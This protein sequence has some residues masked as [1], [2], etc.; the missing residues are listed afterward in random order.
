[1][2]RLRSIYLTS[3]YPQLQNLIKRD[4][5]SYREEYLQQLSH[6]ESSLEIFKLKPDEEAKDF[7]DLIS[8]LCHVSPLFPEQSKDFPQML[9][10][11][12][13]EHYEILNPFVRKAM[14]QGLIL[15]RK[16][17][18]VDQSQ[19]KIFPNNRL[20]SLF[21]KLFRCHDKVLRVV[22][23]HHIVG[24][25][26]NLNKMHKNNRVNSNLQNYMYSMLE[27]PVPIAARKSLLVMID[28]YRKQIW[29]DEKTVN[30][31]A[32][33][34]LKSDSKLISIALNFFLGKMDDPVDDEDDSDDENPIRDIQLSCQVGG[35]SKSKE[36]KLKKALASLRK[37]EKKGSK[38]EAFN[39]P[40]IHL[41]NDPQGFAERLYK[42]L[43]KSNDSFQ[44]RLLMMNVISRLVG[45]HKLFLLGFYPFL[46][47]YLQ[48]HQ[49]EVT[50]IL[51][52]AAQSSHELVPPEEIEPMVKAI[53]NNFVS[54]HC[55]NE[56]MT[57][58]LNSLREICSR[59][60]LAMN[61]TL[62]QDLSNYKKFK[63]KGVMMGARSLIGLYREK[64]PTL[65]HRKDRGKNA[66]SIKDFVVPSYGSVH[67]TK[68][69][70]GVDLVF[71]EDSEWEDEVDDDENSGNFDEEY[72]EC[73]LDEEDMS[74][75][76]E[77][78]GGE[79]ISDPECEVEKPQ[80]ERIEATR[81]LTDNDFKQ[82]RSALRR[83][84][85]GVEPSKRP[86][87]E[88][89]SESEASDG[90]DEIVDQRKI[91]YQSK[92]RKQTKDERMDSIKNGRDGRLKYGSRKGQK[93]RCSSTNQE[94]NKKKNFLMIAHKRKVLAKN[95]M[96]LKQKQAILRRHIEK[97]RKQQ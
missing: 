92:K 89:D 11:L 83:K 91:E 70:E 71:N 60:P 33:A 42:K 65:L 93:N 95:K 68:S 24:D 29:N 13:N 4:A 49:R 82:L 35:K 7:A 25:I 14:A 40:A 88:S 79:Q 48:P 80:S 90:N 45:I 21:F 72:E 16:R 77:D 30:L 34:C 74:D 46:A 15:L 41:I 9:L 63:N 76:E 58:G 51:T 2:G 20:F 12:L 94:K 36:S 57:V 67:V 87:D 32:E 52:I 61:S 28:L 66:S 1:M 50:L 6:F 38:A 56:A 69:I 73:S 8:F 55:S 62:L 5:I 54:D 78:S 53:A 84:S 96:S 18:F 26:K 10:A 37:K 44:V 75:F 64:N 81:I 3:N 59:C 39:F 17:N 27:D 31:I 97:Q 23:F 86:L 43:T 47:R 22:L 85:L 19:Y